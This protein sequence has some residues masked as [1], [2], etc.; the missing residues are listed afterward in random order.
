MREAIAL[1][2]RGALEAAAAIARQACELAGRESGTTSAVY[3]NALTVLATV[4][5][6]AGDSQSAVGI[7][8]S[9]LD[10]SRNDPNAHP[11]LIIW[12]LQSL[13][14]LREELGDLAR[15]RDARRAV[16][17]LTRA[18]GDDAQPFAYSA[19]ASRLALVCE[20]AGDFVEAERLY[21]DAL[22]ALRAG[23][24]PANDV[25][26]ALNNLG[27]IRYER[28]DY[29]AA[30]RY[31]TE[32]LALERGL[33]NT[34]GIASSLNNL[35]C[36]AY[37]QGDFTTAHALFGECLALKRA[38]NIKL[39]TIPVTLVNIAKVELQQGAVQIAEA[40]C[41]EALALWRQLGDGRAIAETL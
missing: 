23:G 22:A 19:A 36:I 32:S 27:M 4:L 41:V 6:R 17:Q 24:A 34:H 28:G 29:E 20:R 13:A 11:R 7:L 15:A 3:A 39:S 31:F 26:S 35:G 18:L 40:H 38:L 16:L 5:R 14:E 8:E 25:A 33:G 12:I 21:R 9:A 10:V 37:D 2:E 30:S 1:S